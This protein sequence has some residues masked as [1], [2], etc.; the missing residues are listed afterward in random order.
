MATR[1]LGFYQPV[2]LVSGL[3]LSFLTSLLITSAGVMISL[4]ASSMRQA[5]QWTGLLMF[6]FMF[7]PLAFI[8][9][10]TVLP[11][12]MQTE[13]MR[14]MEAGNVTP[15]IIGLVL[16]LA[17]INAGLLWLTDRRFRRSRLILD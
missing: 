11:Q 1:T 2:T 14:A 12:A 13:I 15:L 5:Q 8:L 3:A 17:L 9:L 6:S 4:R 16:L 10:V 7:L